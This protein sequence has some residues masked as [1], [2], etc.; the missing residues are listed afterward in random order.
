[1]AKYVDWTDT[2]KQDRQQGIEGTL[3]RPKRS[4][5]SRRDKKPAT[6]SA[7]PKT[8][9]RSATGTTGNTTHKEANMPAVKTSKAPARRRSTKAAEP[10]ALVLSIERLPKGRGGILYSDKEN[11]K[12]EDKLNVTSMYLSQHAVEQMFGGEIPETLTISA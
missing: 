2:Y 4:E 11:H 6:M 5:V 8:R 12:A 1:L 10:E 7:A 3:S 9:R